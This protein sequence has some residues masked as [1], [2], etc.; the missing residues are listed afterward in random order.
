[1]DKRTVS[2]VM[3]YVGSQKSEKKAAS[4]RRNGKLGGRPKK[5]K[6][7]KKTIGAIVL[8]LL[9]S[10]TAQAWPREHRKAW[11]ILSYVGM[12][13]ALADSTQTMAARDYARNHGFGFVEHDPF[14]RPFTNLPAP[15]YVGLS[16]LT[17]GGF[18]WVGQKMQRSNH[19]IVR[20]L[21]W[22]PQ[23]VEI[24]ANVDGIIGTRLHNF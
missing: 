2:E 3:R 11:K 18:S 17:A 10:Q 16:G 14:A 15:V 20:K 1:M 23:A 12:S 7:M 21:W 22:T 4:S 6:T 24:G 19:R 5:E 9:F 8:I 13:L